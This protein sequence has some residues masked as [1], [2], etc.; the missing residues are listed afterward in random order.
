M[1]TP[2]AC[3]FLQCPHPQC[4]HFHPVQWPCGHL[5]QCPH[6]CPLQCPKPPGGSSAGHRDG[7]VRTGHGRDTPSFPWLQLPLEQSPGRHHEHSCLGPGPVRGPSPA[8]ASDTRVPPGSVPMPRKGGRARESTGHGGAWAG[9]YLRRS[10]SGGS[11]LQVSPTALRSSSTSQGR[12]S[13]LATP[14]LL[15]AGLE[16]PGVG[17]TPNTPQETL[18]PPPGSQ[19]RR[20]Q[21]QRDAPGWVN[22]RAGTEGPGTPVPQLV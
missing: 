4:P 13:T 9:F 5:L 17:L 20:G 12:N 6:S 14:A 16:V 8:Q 15:S 1:G 7:G 21:C 10:N 3:Q 11:W 19:G 22:A 18:A 2:V